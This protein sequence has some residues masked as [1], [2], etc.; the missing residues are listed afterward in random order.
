VGFVKELPIET[1]KEG[2]IMSIEMAAPE[3]LDHAGYFWA[4]AAHRESLRGREGFRQ[5]EFRGLLGLEQL[6][7]KHI[8]LTVEQTVFFGEQLTLF[9]D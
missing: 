5:P 6:I 8:S 1:I 7:A 4:L 3:S 9:F 2:E